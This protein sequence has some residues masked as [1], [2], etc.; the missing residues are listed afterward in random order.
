MTAKYSFIAF[1]ILLFSVETVLSQPSISDPVYSKGYSAFY[2]R[3]W[4]D[5]TR[6]L[7]E[8][9][10]KKPAEFSDSKFKH[11]V[12]EAYSFALNK[13]KQQST[14]AATD[15]N[16]DDVNEIHSDLETMPR[17]PRPA[18]T[19][20]VRKFQTKM[21]FLSDLD[22][23][24]TSNLYEGLGK[25]KP[26]WQ[27]LIS[28]NQVVYPKGLVTFPVAGKTGAVEYD[29]DGEYGE[30]SFV[31]GIATNEH[32]DPCSG[33]VNFRVYSD[34][35]L[36]ASK[37]VRATDDI[38]TIDFSIMGTKILRLEVDDAGDGNLCDYAVWA[39]AKVIRK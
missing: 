32:I 4:I 36:L 12:T 25:N 5:A 30:L 10:Q 7:L 14:P 38:F 23:L 19:I 27:N 3:N 11:D 20:M 39:D 24:L 28:L 37:L 15:D 26:Y 29:L 1:I 17:I 16:A 21:V 34:G 33:S 13:L 18:T 6:Y 2:K 35:K 31:A 8:Y 22:E 9:I